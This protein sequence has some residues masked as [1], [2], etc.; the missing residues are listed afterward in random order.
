[1]H[2][3]ENLPKVEDYS[4]IFQ[5]LVASKQKDIIQNRN[6]LI[7]ALNSFANVRLKPL[8][9]LTISHVKNAVCTDDTVGINIIGQ[10]KTGKKC[11]LNISL[12]LFEELKHFCT[13]LMTEQE[14]TESGK[15]PY[16]NHYLCKK[17]YL[18]LFMNNNVLLYH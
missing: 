12:E 13:R 17:N 18:T 15:V 9:N 1:L 5:N 2:S 10:H 14:A 7:L 4:K 8:Q 11:D 3:K 6:C 16:Y